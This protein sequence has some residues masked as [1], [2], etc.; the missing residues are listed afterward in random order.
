MLKLLTGI[1]AALLLAG[2]AVA[3]PAAD[4]NRLFA[5]SRLVVRDRFSDEIVGKGPD[6]VF[7]PGLASSRLTRL[8][9]RTP[10]DDCLLRMTVGW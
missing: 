5:D 7:I 2:A 4:P 9:C 3:Q 6:L 8:P 10:Q 1:A